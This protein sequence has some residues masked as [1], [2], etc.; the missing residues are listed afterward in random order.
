MKTNFRRA[1]VFGVMALVA[2]AVITT[3][4]AQTTGLGGAG[5]NGLVGRTFGLGVTGIAILVIVA[6]PVLLVLRWLTVGRVAVPRL[7]W[8]LIGATVAT[9]PVVA[10][11]MPG[12]S[13]SAK[14]IET[15]DA[16]P[17]VIASEWVPLVV[18]GGVF[19]W[20]FFFP[21]RP[22]AGTTG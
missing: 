18:G 17:L 21:N 11:N 9:V 10:M 6:T 3:P 4:F 16:S 7:A 8:A 1:L 20:H 22:R 12:E 19:G 2:L 15:L 14:I 13:L 5:L